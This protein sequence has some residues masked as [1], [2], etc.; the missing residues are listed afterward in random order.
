MQDMPGESFEEHPDPTYLLQ[1][2]LDAVVTTDLDYRITSW[3]RAAE[4]LYGWA[5]AE[6]I[7][8]PAGE[9]LRTE[10][11]GGER[12]QLLEQFQAAGSWRGELVHHHRDGHALAILASVSVLRGPDGKPQGM[13]MVNRDITERKAAEQASQRAAKRLNVLA[14][15]SR[16]FAEAEADY[17][18]VL[19]LVAQRVVEALGDFC[20]I[21]MLSDDQQLLQAVALYYYDPSDTEARGFIQNMVAGAPLRPDEPSI[22]ARVFQSGQSLLVPVIDFAQLQARIKPEYRAGIE[23]FRPHSMIV[24]P[25]KLQNRAIGLFGLYRS[26]PHWPAFSEDDLRLAQDLADRAALALGNAQLFARVQVELAARE[27][28]KKATELLHAAGQLLARPLDLDQILE[29]LLDVLKQLIPYDSANIMLPEEPGTFRVR[30]LRGYERWT[31]PE[32]VKA[33]RFDLTQRPPIAEIVEQRRSRLIPDVHQ[34]P[35]WRPMLDTAY[36]GCWLGVPLIAENRLVGIYSIDRHEPH[37]LTAHDVQLAET[38]AASAAAALERANLFT[39]LREERALLARRVAERTADLSSV[40]AE[41]ARAVRLK[42]DFLANMSHE[43]RT[44]LNTILGRSEAI[45]EEIYGPVTPKQAEVLKGLS[46]SGQHLLSLI[47]DILDLSK[48]EAGRLELIRDN[49]NVDL[50]CNACLRMVAQIAV[51]RHIS[52]NFSLD[53][54][55]EIISADERRLKQILVNLLSNAVKFTPEGGRVG[56]DVRGALSQ[57]AV[58]F[59]VW[60][61]GIGIAPDELPKLFQPFVQIDS[62]LSREYQGT[63]LGLALVRRLAEAHSGSV[64]VESMPGKGSRFSITIPWD[65]APQQL[66]RTAIAPAVDMSVPKVGQALIV[67]DSTTAADQIRRYLQELGARAEVVA[68]G[69]GAVERAIALQPDVIILDIL[70]PD[71]DGWSVLQQL[72]AEPRTQAIPVVVVSVV[73]AP[74]RAHELGATGM[75]LKPID[76]AALVGVLRNVTERKQPPIVER[77]LVVA[78]HAHRP[79]VLLAEDNPSNIDTL[80]DYLQA[81]GYAVTVARNGAEALI[82]AQEDRPEVILMDIQMPGMDGLETIQRLRANENTQDL[83]IIAVTALAMPGDRERCLAAGA[84]EYVRKPVPLRSL[85]TTIEAHREKRAQRGKDT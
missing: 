29:T 16:A 59:T 44:P 50:L 22:D 17:Q 23:R 3:N 75:V 58:T 19:N 42:D 21:R 74:A 27:Q 73:D 28:A 9:L 5:A 84:D 15:A 43:L 18:S 37:S 32:R 80:Y 67:E 64:A 35:S 54:T 25:L 83:L 33:L 1:V 39:T 66:A 47:N 41:L 70:L 20:I 65:P 36:V 77:A 78:G 7:G 26:R 10:Y 2:M 31:D 71:A 61:T 52:L 11:P 40:N 69:T 8:Q 62:S 72:K 30:Y 53:P 60:D 46:E 4:E 82:R 13:V 56:L 14:E 12:A 24:V 81:K 49:L 45:Q 48:I 68:Y 85:V 55:V 63:G 6:A 57:D 34:E 51:V 76:R 38:L 79:R